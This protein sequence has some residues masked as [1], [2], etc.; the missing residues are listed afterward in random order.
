MNHGKSSFA[1]KESF[2]NQSRSPD[3]GQLDFTNVD[4]STPQVDDLLD[5]V[6]VRTYIDNADN[7]YGVINFKRRILLHR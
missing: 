5:R 4:S 2:V 7:E 1:L 6:G 3:L